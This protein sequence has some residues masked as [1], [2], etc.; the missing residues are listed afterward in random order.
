M[1]AGAIPLFFAKRLPND[2]K[3]RRSRRADRRSAVTSSPR[4]YFLHYESRAA[5]YS[6][7]WA[8]APQTAYLGLLPS[9]KCL[10]TTL[11]LPTYQIFINFFRIERL[12]IWVF[13]QQC[14]ID[15][16]L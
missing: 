14:Q 12:N 2:K 15:Q 1:K 4:Q 13:M 10:T 6:A 11:F 16:C 5:S 9:P 8:F 7:P 3:S